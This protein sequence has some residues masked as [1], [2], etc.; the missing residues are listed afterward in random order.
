MAAM[1]RHRYLLISAKY[2]MLGE[3]V[4]KSKIPAWPVTWE[5]N[6]LKWV[7]EN[8]AISTREGFYTR[9]YRFKMYHQLQKSDSESQ[10][11]L[12]LCICTELSHFESHW[13]K[14]FVSQL[15]FTLLPECYGSK[16]SACFER[17]LG[18]PLCKLTTKAGRLRFG[19]WNKKKER[20]EKRK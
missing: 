7:S 16:A 3:N 9:C 1:H 10:I 4:S 19:E 8:I 17:A 12:F 20:K 14:V 18:L 15:M 11:L 13:K 6:R 5:E 2:F